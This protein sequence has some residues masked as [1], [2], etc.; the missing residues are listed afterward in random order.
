MK[1]KRVNCRL[2]EQDFNKLMELA[3]PVGGIGKWI[4]LMLVRTSDPIAVHTEPDKVQDVSTNKPLNKPAV[5][6]E[7][8]V[9]CMLKPIV[10]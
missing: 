3:K 5:R 8:K 2:S 1:D 6:T 10:G 4:A 9:N 7:R